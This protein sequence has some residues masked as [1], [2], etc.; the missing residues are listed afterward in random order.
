MLLR[1]RQ[2]HYYNR[3]IDM[4]GMELKHIFLSQMGEYTQSAELDYPSCA[5]NISS[6]AIPKSKSNK[7]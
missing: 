3:G 5:T 7:Q 1:S 6:A 4:M 2:D